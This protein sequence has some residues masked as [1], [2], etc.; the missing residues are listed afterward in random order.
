MR[1]LTWILKLDWRLNDVEVEYW[2]NLKLRLKARVSISTKEKC[3][4]SL[5]LNEQEFE[6]E[7]LNLSTNLKLKTSLNLN[8]LESEFEECVWA[9]MN[10]NGNE[11]VR[12]GIWEIKREC[13]WIKTRVILEATTV[14]PEQPQLLQ[15]VVATE[16]WL[17]GPTVLLQI[18]NFFV[19]M[20]DTKSP[21]CN[22]E[23]IHNAQSHY[24]MHK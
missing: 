13:E 11:S 21:K 10:G 14:W 19:V 2:T 4:T 18:P 5:N 7:Q 9:K 12:L 16:V 23:P 6:F 3:R 20:V 1:N 8:E 15:T 17:N 24:L 22:L